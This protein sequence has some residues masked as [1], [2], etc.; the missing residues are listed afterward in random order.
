MQMAV[1]LA[2]TE[3]LEGIYPRFPQPL[4]IEDMNQNQILRAIALKRIQQYATLREASESLN[5]DIRTL[6]RYTQWTE[7][8][9]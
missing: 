1:A 9:K 3:K 2:T 5:I 4:N 6:Q 7:S 8:D